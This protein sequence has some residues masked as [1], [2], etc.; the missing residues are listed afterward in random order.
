[1]T[2]LTQVAALTA[3]LSVVALGSYWFGR[4]DARPLEPSKAPIA[5]LDNAKVEVARGE[6]GT[7]RLNSVVER[8]E[9]RLGELEAKQAAVEPTAPGSRQLEE[10]EPYDPAAEE[11]KRLDR[12]AAI[13]AALHTETRDIAWA[14][15]TENALRAAVDSAVREDAKFSVQSVNCLT[16]LC[17]MVLTAA[18]PDDLKSVARQLASKVTGMNSFDVPPPV[19]APDGRATV[20]CRLFREGFPRPDAAVL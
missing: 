19:V 18:N 17:E 20:T 3:G 4:R 8:L 7:A 10:N 2:T 14:R 12:L 16:S 11:Q 6:P 15:P 13:D 9:H 1:M 5:A